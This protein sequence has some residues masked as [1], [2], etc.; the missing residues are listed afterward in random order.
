MKNGKR[1]ENFFIFFGV[2]E[3]RSQNSKSKL[4]TRSDLYA[5]DMNTV[6]YHRQI[7]ISSVDFLLKKNSL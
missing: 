7:F 3:Y 4:V 5:N 6:Y 1:V 2:L